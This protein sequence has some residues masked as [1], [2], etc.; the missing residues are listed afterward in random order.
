MVDA[1]NIE[2]RKLFLRKKDLENDSPS[3]YQSWLST[4]RPEAI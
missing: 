4:P 3:A 2:P 1:I